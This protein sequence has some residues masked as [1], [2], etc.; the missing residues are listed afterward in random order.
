MKYASYGL[1]AALL[2][3]GAYVA[4]PTSAEG[5]YTPSGGFTRQTGSV[6]VFHLDDDGADC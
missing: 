1:L 2:A 6:M 3:L 5:W 4:M